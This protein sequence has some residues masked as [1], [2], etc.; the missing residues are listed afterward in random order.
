LVILLVALAAWTVITPPPVPSRTAL[1]DVEVEVGRATAVPVESA[2][3]VVLFRSTSELEVLSVVPNLGFRPNVLV[4]SGQV[5]EVE[6]RGGDE[7]LVFTASL[8][9]G[10]VQTSITSEDPTTLAAAT[11]TTASASTTSTTG[12]PVAT[13]ALPTTT[14]PPSTTASVVTTA[15]P[16]T[17]TSAPTTT[18]TVLPTT[19]TT[20]APTTTTTTIPTTT[21]APSSIPTGPVGYTLGPAGEIVVTYADELFV[22]AIIYLNPGWEIADS[23][24]GPT[25]IWLVATSDETTVLWSAEIIDGEV[26]IDLDVENDD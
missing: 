11:P 25:R 18:T 6:F 8:E 24:G 10:R 23:G 14:A 22:D 19:T 5:V 26:D 1:E 16:T 3:H 12:A 4:G 2:G 20:V 15:P 21:T 13:V 17:T 7:R 9:G